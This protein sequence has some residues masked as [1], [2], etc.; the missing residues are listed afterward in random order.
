MLSKIWGL[1]PARRLQGECP[2]PALRLRI[3][4]V[5]RRNR[6]GAGSPEQKPRMHLR[7][8]ACALGS[9]H[10]PR[11]RCWSDMGRHVMQTGTQLQPEKPSSPQPLSRATAGLTPAGEKSGLTVL[12]P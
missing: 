4:R 9:S 5:S 12:S 11:G 8:L 10:P 3:P 1:P 7:G 6:P 2:A